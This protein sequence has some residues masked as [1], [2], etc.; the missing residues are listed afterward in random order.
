[1]CVSP[2]ATENRVETST[3]QLSTLFWQLCPGAE[4]ARPVLICMALRL[5]NGPYTCLNKNTGS[6]RSSMHSELV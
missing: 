4:K 1:M 5:G 6:Q 3:R 2:F